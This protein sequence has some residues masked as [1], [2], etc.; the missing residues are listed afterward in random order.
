MESFSLYINIFSRSYSFLSYVE[1][2]LWGSKNPGNGLFQK[3]PLIKKEAYFFVL[4]LYLLQENSYSC[5]VLKFQVSKLKILEG[6]NK[7]IN[8]AAKVLI[9]KTLITLKLVDLA[10]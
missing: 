4:F 5:M 1:K 6:G 3:S 10:T 9:F 7:I 2:K 8:L